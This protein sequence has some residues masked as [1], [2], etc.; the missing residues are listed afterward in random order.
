MHQFHLMHVLFQMFLPPSTIC[1]TLNYTYLIL[2]FFLYCL[3]LHLKK[4]TQKLLIA[5]TDQ[6]IVKDYSKEWL[7][8]HKQWHTIHRNVAQLHSE[9]H[10]TGTHR[11]RR[12][13]RLHD[14]AP[15]PFKLKSQLGDG[16]DRSTPLEWR[17]VYPLSTNKSHLKFKVQCSENDAVEEQNCI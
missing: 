1:H 16:L 5:N 13:I 10:N 6:I 12:L 3:S 4:D 8:L 17:S 9:I 14:K 11:A 2:P 7:C 15:R